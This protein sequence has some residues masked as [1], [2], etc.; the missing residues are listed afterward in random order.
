LSYI[1]LILTLILLFL[2]SQVL[3]HEGWIL[4]PS[5]MLLLNGK[6]KPELFTQWSTINTV[7]L[8]CALLLAL[9]WV[10]LR[11][12]GAR[13]MF[14]DLQERLSSYSEY[15]AVILRLCLTWALLASAFAL[16]PRVGNTI[17]QSPTLLAPD[18][19]LRMLD[20]QWMWIREAQ[21]LLAIMFL[22]GIYVRAAAVLLIAVCVLGCVIFGHDMATY[23]TAVV[24][25]AIYLLLQGAGSR[26]IPL[27]VFPQLQPLVTRFESVPRQRA[28]FLL[29][30]LAGLNFL[31]LGVYFKVLQPNL[32]LGIVEI[33]KVPILSLAPEFFV[34]IMAVIE[35]LIGMFLIMGVLVRPVSI[36]LLCA[37]I[38]FATFLDESYT[39]HIIFYGIVLT[40]LFNSAGHWRRPEATD[41]AAQ[42]V[43]L[44]GGLAAIRAAM[45]LE[46]LRGSFYSRLCCLKWLAVPYNRPIL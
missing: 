3:A 30:I 32:A 37:F 35:T 8:S 11:Y 36:F 19:E 43:I 6:A 16:E 28:Q 26:H 24:G 45:K 9:F 44:G 38:F 18:L 20:S 12:T 10:K 1:R 33:Y 25:I 14:P 40:F 29:R 4:T 5:E 17:F 22:F 31:Y 27:P 46:K 39:A 34:L 15:S 7:V 42:I 21:I 23:F 2:S 41:K 13:E